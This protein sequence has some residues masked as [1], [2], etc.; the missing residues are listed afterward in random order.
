M[1]FWIALD[2]P[3]G[4]VVR[5][6]ALA[7]LCCRLRDELSYISR[8][9]FWQVSGRSQNMSAFFPILE[10]R[11]VFEKYVH[12]GADR[13]GCFHPWAARKLALSSFYI[14][15]IE[16]KRA[17]N[18][19]PFLTYL[20]HF[21]KV[22]HFSAPN[23]NFDSGDGSNSPV[24]WSWSFLFRYLPMDAKPICPQVINP[25]LLIIPPPSP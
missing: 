1:L 16:V 3:H 10:G 5:L 24:V 13:G 2:L 21:K 6:K 20:H 15:F 7:A 8:L 14:Q 12:E 11:I 19:W 22:L 18:L 4:L 9:R 25:Q 17:S 23:S